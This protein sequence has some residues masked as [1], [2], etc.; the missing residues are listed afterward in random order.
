MARLTYQSLRS[1][2]PVILGAG[3]FALG[4]YALY[5]LLK[6]VNPADV[7]AQIRATPAST[8]AAALG[9][10]IIGY[11]AL[12]LYDWFGLRFIGK[13]LD[14]GIVA[15]GGFL[16]YAFGNTIGVSV[17]SGGAVRYRI[18]SA[19]GLNAFEVAAVSGYIAVALGTGLT[20]VG[21]AALAIHPG[22]VGALLPY[23][24][25]TIQ[26]VAAA[27]TALSVALITWMSVSQRSLSIR[28]HELHLPPP[29]DLVGQLI[30]T[31]IDIAAASFALWVL[32]PAGKPDYAT[33]VAVYAAATMIG[34][35]SHVP[36]GVGV[37]ETVVIGT[38]PATVSVGD[39]AAA[40]L[41]F[42][43][44]YYLVPFALAFL[45]VALNEIR[46]ASGLG[47]RL[48]ARAPAV[49]TGFATLHGLSPGLVAVVAFGRLLGARTIFVES[50]GS[51]EPTLAGRL[52]Y[53]FADLFIVQWPE[54]LRRFPRAVLADGPLL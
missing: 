39:A 49:Q 45:L 26:I 41:I 6:P 7:A 4:L 47:T 32:L 34:V 35:L 17:I 22:A 42:R 13:T 30:V 29:A 46:L 21:V 18:Y 43:L 11:V 44:V 24:P 16:G 33:F 50:A 3:L 5:H 51:L 38:L 54:A 27:I 52:A 14:R 1:A 19:V 9:A 25:S 10:T 12:V 28:G 2:A 40:L 31:C 53:P 36:G 8:L 23:A 48:L 20:L 15:L 37:F